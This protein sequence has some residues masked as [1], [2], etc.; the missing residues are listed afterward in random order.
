MVKAHVL[1]LMVAFSMALPSVGAA[2]APEIPMPPGFHTLTVT[3]EKS[4]QLVVAMIPQKIGDKIAF[5]GAMWPGKG[6]KVALSRRHKV[7][8][9]T[10]IRV[11]GKA[12]PA[13]LS[14]FPV[15]DS[16][17]AANVMRCTVTN[18]PWQGPY[19]AK[20]IVMKLSSSTIRD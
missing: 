17:A 20:D 8:S 6:S 18:R 9:A 2:A 13:Q 16:E 10:V 12:V 3:L 11:R 14:V 1:G 19:K 5:C 7:L 4:S 15:Y